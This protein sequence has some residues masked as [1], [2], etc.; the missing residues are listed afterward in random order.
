MDKLYFLSFLYFSYIS[1]QLKYKL[2]FGLEMKISSGFSVFQL[3]VGL[4]LLILILLFKAF[5]S[6]TPSLTF[7]Q[8]LTVPEPVPLQADLVG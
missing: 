8:F 1:K 4:G 7:I 3:L 2:K 5:L 6:L